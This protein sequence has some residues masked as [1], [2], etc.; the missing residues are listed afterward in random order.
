M[1]TDDEALAHCVRALR[2]YGSEVKYDHRLRGTNSRLDELQ[3]AMLRVKLKYVD[4]DSRLRRGVATRYREGI[5]HPA[6]AVPS[7]AREE[8]H[9]WHLFVVRCGH[10]DALQRHLLAH[11]I[12][13]Q[14]HYPLPP[15]LQPA[16]R[17]L[18]HARLP[19][20]ERLHGEV[21]SLPISPTL[22]DRQ[23]QRVVD[24]CNAF[25]AAA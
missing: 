17:T 20:T 15:H 8:A 16:Y 1:T 22:S 7:A 4:E 10:R 18:P 21:L 25:G 19:L 6:I 9:A 2:N 14:V 11:G 24:A 3:A 13:T 5:R 12:Q 23:V